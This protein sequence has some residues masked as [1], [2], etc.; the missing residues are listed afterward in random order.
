MNAKTFGWVF[1]LITLAG[2]IL[3]M[4]DIIRYIKMK[5]M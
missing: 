2:I 1:G 5:T 4:K 3:N